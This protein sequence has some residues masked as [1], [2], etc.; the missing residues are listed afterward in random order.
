MSF[1]PPPP[2]RRPIAEVRRATIDQISQVGA[3]DTWVSG[4]VRIEGVGEV[5]VEVK[6][7]V[8]FGERP[9]PLLGAA[10]IDPSYS[11]REG[12]FPEVKCAITRWD[13]IGKTAGTDPADYYTGVQ[14]S[15]RTAG[16][17]DQRVWMSYAFVGTAL[18]NIA[19][20]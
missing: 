4:R 20:D 2:F 18:T 14:I 13:T 1:S 9:L 3:Q 8:T 7:P 11:P 12:F 19:T 15:V 6:F 10:E 5:L 17:R 16:D